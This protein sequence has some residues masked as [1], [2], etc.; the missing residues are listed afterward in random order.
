MVS[1]A[2]PRALPRAGAFSFP[3]LGKMHRGKKSSQQKENAIT[4]GSAPAILIGHVRGEM[5]PLHTAAEQAM[6]THAV[7]PSKAR[8]VESCIVANEML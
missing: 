1:R 8:K 6:P 5:S 7:L 4:G 3:P 2:F